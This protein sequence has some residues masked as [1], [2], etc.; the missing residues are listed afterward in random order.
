M[1]VHTQ[2]P[3]AG[4]GVRTRVRMRGFIT[5]GP[6]TR[7]SKRQGLGPCVDDPWIR[8]EDSTLGTWAGPREGL[9]A[10]AGSGP[11]CE[12]PPGLLG[13]ERGRRTGMCGLPRTT[14]PGS[15]AV[16]HGRILAVSD[17][18]QPIYDLSFRSSVQIRSS[19]GSS[20]DGT[21]S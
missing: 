13:M 10:G 18:Q 9:L 14:F 16:P 20:S 2:G 15:W 17:I 7:G 1:R 6:R 21:A 19:G 11:L 3:L 4:T 5:Q 12:I 8:L